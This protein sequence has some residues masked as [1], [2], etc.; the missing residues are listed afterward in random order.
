MKEY[1]W[2]VNKTK[3]GRAISQAKLYETEDEAEIKKLYISYGGLVREIPK[4]KVAKL[5]DNKE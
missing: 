2:A 3:L 1:S 5:E 4:K